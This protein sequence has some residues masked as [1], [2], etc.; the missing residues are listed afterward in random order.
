MSNKTPEVGQ[1]VTLTTW[2]DAISGTIVRVTPKTITFRRDKTTLLNGPL[3][4]EPDALVMTPGGFAAHTT[5]T[6][7]WSTEPDPEGRLY[8][9]TLR[10]NGKWKLAGHPTRS[11]GNLVE[12]GVR[13]PHYDFNF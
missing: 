5:G 10:K 8:K 4:G 13:K 3:S 7:R 9:A 1:G 12:I 2:T 6:Q 11:P